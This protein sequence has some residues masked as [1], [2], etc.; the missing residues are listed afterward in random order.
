MKA[1]ALQKQ[2]KCII[3]I[4]MFKRW[5]IKESNCHRQTHI[6]IFSNLF[7]CMAHSHKLL[8]SS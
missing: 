1:L 8:H 4:I 7:N 3:I 6:I 5:V 2:H